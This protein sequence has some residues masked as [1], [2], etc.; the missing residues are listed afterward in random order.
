M[1]EKQTYT[2]VLRTINER[3]SR[4]EDH[5]GSLRTAEAVQEEKFVTARTVLVWIG[6][7][8]VAVVSALAS[9]LALK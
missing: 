9:I 1:Q 6:A 4:L 2:D 7:S 5:V 3:L 8:V